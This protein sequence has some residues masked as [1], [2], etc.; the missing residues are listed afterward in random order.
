MARIVGIIPARAGS[1]GIPGKNF[2]ALAGFPL[3][4][5]ITAAAVQSHI[6]ELYIST[7]DVTAAKTAAAPGLA[8]LKGSPMAILTRPV[9]LS[10]DDTPDLPVFQHLA[11]GLHLAGEDILVH[12][13]PTSPFVCPEDINSVV[14]L[15]LK[16]DLPEASVRSV[17]P[18]REHPA[19][20]YA[21]GMRLTLETTSLVPF[22]GRT[23]HRAN[24]S[25]QGLS[26]PFLAAGFVDALRVVNVLTGFGG[27]GSMDGWPILA[28]PAPEDRAMDLDTEAD[29]AA[30]E[31]LAKDNGWRPGKIG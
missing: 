7:D 10:Q 15:L 24:H 20:M 29:W 13:R 14:G 5:W 21:E 4:S 16:Y 6:H 19:K 1:K 30:A 2:R 25:R 18:A 12:L 28:W 22:L 31:Q 26:K 9:E 3:L 23:E 17:I 8:E 11:R 27:T